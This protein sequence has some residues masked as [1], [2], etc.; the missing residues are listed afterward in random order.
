M[1]ELSGRVGGEYLAKLAYY[2][3][4]GKT[5]EKEVS[6]VRTPCVS[7]WSYAD[8]DVR[9]PLMKF[10]VL[11]SGSSGNAV[12]IAS[13]NTKVLIDAG[14]SAREIVRRLA[15]VGVDPAA[16]DGIV[17]THEHSDHIGGLKN[18]LRLLNCP[19]YI[20]GDTEEAYYGTRK[21]HENGE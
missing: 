7:G 19:V 18:L 9:V 4:C 21:T 17:I 16:L 3:S 10:T 1:D 13:E 14:L 2:P 12:L 20:T 8:V 5:F 15:L 11:G 6:K